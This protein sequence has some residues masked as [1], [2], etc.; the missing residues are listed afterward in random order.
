MK[1]KGN[2]NSKAKS[3]HFKKYILFIFREGKGGRR[4]E[5]HQSVAS[6]THP[7]IG[8]LA[9]NPGLCPDWESNC[10][11]LSL[12]AGTQSTEPHLPEPNTFDSVLMRRGASIYTIAVNFVGLIYSI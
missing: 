5:K 10:R 7:L 9:R 11:P 1:L 3:E 2:R 12:Q 6:R 4:R 8:D